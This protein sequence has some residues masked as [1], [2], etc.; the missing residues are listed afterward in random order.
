VQ[1]YGVPIQ[2]PDRPVSGL[3]HSLQHPFRHAECLL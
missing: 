2:P 3:A 1:F